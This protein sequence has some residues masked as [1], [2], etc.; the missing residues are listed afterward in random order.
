[1]FFPTC[2][3]I[4][5]PICIQ[6]LRCEKCTGAK[7]ACVLN[8]FHRETCASCRKCAQKCSNVFQG[9]GGNQTLFAYRAYCWLRSASSPDKYNFPVKRTHDPRMQHVDQVPSWFYDRRKEVAPEGQP[10]PLGD[11]D[12]DQ[13]PRVRLGPSPLQEAVVFET[14]AATTGRIADGDLESMP[15]SRREQ[16]ASAS[17]ALPASSARQAPDALAAAPRRKASTKKSV[18]RGKQPAPPAPPV[19]PEAQQPP[20]KKPRRAEV[21]VLIPPARRGAEA[22]T[23]ESGAKPSQDAG[24]AESAEGGRIVIDLVNDDDTEMQDVSAGEFDRP[25]RHP[26]PI[27]TPLIPP[28]ADFDS[29]ATPA[30][31]GG[32]GKGVDRRPSHTVTAVEPSAPP[33][34]P[35]LDAAVQGRIHPRWPDVV[36]P[37]YGWLSLSTS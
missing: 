4:T 26:V 7:K 15:R 36:P 23:Q 32:K 3:T 34:E 16:G 24:A 10:V 22:T 6:A 21:Y 5:H 30:Q 13:G 27:L 11:L 37:H 12:P 29:A 1:M 19:V 9:N 31:R 17:Q 14:C 25:V 33:H 2:L 18:P 28:D 8:P 35:P 20:S